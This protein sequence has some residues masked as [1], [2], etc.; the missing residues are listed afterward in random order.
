MNEQCLVLMWSLYFAYHSH[1]YL[2]T[3]IQLIQYNVQN[4]P[5]AN[6]ARFR[7]REVRN[8][9]Y[10]RREA[11]L[12]MQQLESQSEGWICFVSVQRRGD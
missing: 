9:E 12:K 10:E 6:L 4:R 3:L 11:A 7:E 2:G 5:G 8:S 1:N